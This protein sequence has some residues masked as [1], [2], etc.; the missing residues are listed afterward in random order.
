MLFEFGTITLLDELSSKHLSETQILTIL[1]DVCESLS[2]IHN[3]GIYHLDL[4]PQNL[5]LVNNRYKI[6]DFGSAID[7]KVTFDQLEKKKASS[8]IEYIETN[9]TLNYRSPEMIEPF[10][11]VIGA[12]SDIWMLGCI[13]YLLTFRKHPF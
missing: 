10:G 5:I 6:C 3:L 4:K 12:A 9:S 7:T 11:K 1:K 13:T 2:E 8:F